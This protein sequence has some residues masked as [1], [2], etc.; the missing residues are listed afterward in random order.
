MATLRRR[1]ILWCDKNDQIMLSKVP[2]QHARHHLL[3]SLPGTGPAGQRQSA[4]NHLSMLY[5]SLLE[6]W[7]CI[8]QPSLC[9]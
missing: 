5:P 8:Y 4:L 2:N 7:H 6:E 3:E 9:P 1:R